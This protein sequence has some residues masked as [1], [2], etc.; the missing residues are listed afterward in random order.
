MG[1]MNMSVPRNSKK[2]KD[3]FTD[4]EL[5]DFS[6]NVKTTQASLSLDTATFKQIPQNF[7]R[8]KTG[9][10]YSTKVVI[11]KKKEQIPE[12]APKL[13]TEPSFRGLKSP[14]FQIKKMGKSFKNQKNQDLAISFTTAAGSTTAINQ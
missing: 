7:A 14:E 5:H 13:M 6:R 12:Q 4:I 10:T 11:P 3:K 1:K 9:V 2:P 8:H